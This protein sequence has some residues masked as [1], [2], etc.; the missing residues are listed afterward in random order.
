[1]VMNLDIVK[2]IYTN[3]FANTPWEDFVDQL[4][5]GLYLIQDSDDLSKRNLSDMKAA[6]IALTYNRELMM[7]HLMD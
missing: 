2:N 7:Y 3:S 1:M 6:N 5:T 4:E